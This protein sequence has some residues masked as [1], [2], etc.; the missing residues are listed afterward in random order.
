MS[1]TSSRIVLCNCLMCSSV[2]HHGFQDC[3]NEAHYYVETHAVDACDQFEGQSAKAT[4]CMECFD[5]YV[6]TANEIIHEGMTGKRTPVC[7]GQGCDRYLTRMSHFFDVIEPA[8][9]H[10]A[11]LGEDE[12]HTV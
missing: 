9:S 10:I 3:D 12:I 1:Q 4:V 5:A 2:F 6:A 8:A 7:Q 11:E